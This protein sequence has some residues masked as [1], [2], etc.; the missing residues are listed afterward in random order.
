[1]NY[2]TFQD[3]DGAAKVGLKK[4]NKKKNKKLKLW[5]LLVLQQLV[6]KLKKGVKIWL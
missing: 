1:M 6:F 5:D 2:S 4:K 3:Q